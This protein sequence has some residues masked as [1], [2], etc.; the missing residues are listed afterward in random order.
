MTNID[1]SNYFKA[2]GNSLA[3][4]VRKVE[5]FEVRKNGSVEIHGI[6]VCGRCGGCGNYSFCPRY[7]T[8]CFQCSGSG[9]VRDKVIGYTAEQIAKKEA[10]AAAKRERDHAAFVAKTEA[11]K[12]KNVAAFPELQAVIDSLPSANNIV[13]DIMSKIEHY[14]LSQKQVDLVMKIHNEEMARREE[15]ANAGDA[16]FGKQTVEGEVVFTKW[17]DNDFGGALKCMVK[18]DNG[19]KVYGTVPSRSD[20]QK[21]DRVKFS[22][23]FEV[24]R[25]DVSFGYYKRPTKPEII[26]AAE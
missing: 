14:D 15:K 1:L 13:N 19:A 22:A 11:Q 9:K 26:K 12:A 17:M 8:T 18:L 4:F 10:K 5:S 24:S 25:D 7:G 3:G 2:N 23:T 21:G 20:W 16:P 6:V